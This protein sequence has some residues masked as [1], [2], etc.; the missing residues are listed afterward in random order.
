MGNHL[1]W[2]FRQKR[3]QSCLQNA[4]NEVSTSPVHSHRLLP[5]TLSGRKNGHC[6]GLKEKELHI[7]RFEK[8]FSFI[9]NPPL[10]CWKCFVFFNAAQRKWTSSAMQSSVAAKPATQAENTWSGRREWLVKATNKPWEAAWVK[11]K[12]GEAI[13][14]RTT[15]TWLFSA[16]VSE[17]VFW[18]GIFP[19]PKSFFNE[20]VLAQSLTKNQKNTTFKRSKD[21]RI[22]FESS[23]LGW[24]S[25]TPNGFCRCLM[26]HMKYSLVP[27][28]QSQLEE[29][30][31]GTNGK[32]ERRKTKSVLLDRK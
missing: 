4:G 15:E 23:I 24:N 21:A 22:I 25:F 9:K 5:F 6:C 28:S 32:K 14:A 16:K 10:K 29:R 31:S 27:R 18:F 13:T 20:L 8:Q 30:N 26:V 1:F 17:N 19:E 3:H 11:V 2:K 7:Y 12:P